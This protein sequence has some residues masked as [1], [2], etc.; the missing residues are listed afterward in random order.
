MKRFLAVILLTIT[1]GTVFSAPPAY[2]DDWLKTNGSNAAAGFLAAIGALPVASFTAV[3]T[4]AAD[5]DAV[6]AALATETLVR[7]AA[8]ATHTADI[9]AV[10]AALATDVADLAGHIA[11]TTDVHGIAAAIA[12]ETA[13]RQAAD[14]THTADIDLL[15]QSLATDVQN[16]ADHL[17]STTDAHG[18]RPMAFQPVENFVATDTFTGHTGATSG[19]HG[20]PADTR[21]LTASETIADA[22]IPAEIARDNE[23]PGNASFT[24][25]G[26]LSKAFSELTDLPTTLGGYGIT[27]AASPSYVDGAIDADVATVAA[28]ISDHI[29]STTD[30]HG[31]ETLVFVSSGTGALPAVGPVGSRYTDLSTSTAPVDYR[32][33]GSS[34]VM[35]SDKGGGLETD[36]EWSGENKFS[37]EILALDLSV[38][39]S[40]TSERSGKDANDVFTTITWKDDA[41]KVRKK[42]ILSGGTSPEYATRTECLYDTDGVAT[43][44]ERVYE[45]SYDGDG[46]WDGETYVP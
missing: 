16:L 42:S 13:D 19:V 22:Q 38:A 20:A 33:N 25:A 3:A 14:A 23:I 26:L 27:D 32:S 29:A 12:T 18:L 36:N 17:A 37:G 45:Q 7:A 44:S 6:E 31:L 24:L 35:L 43:L 11:S 15:E 34:W 28:T 5:L 8:D 39:I 21:F 9:D 4:I 46:D 40:C 30:V 1:T 41:G 2:V 10:E